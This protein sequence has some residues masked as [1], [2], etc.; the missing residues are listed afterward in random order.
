MNDL[1]HDSGVG[2]SSESLVELFK[3]VSAIFPFFFFLKNKQ[4]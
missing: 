3:N 4:Q 1:F 2:A